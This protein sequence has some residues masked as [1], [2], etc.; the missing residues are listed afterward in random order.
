MD[1]TPSVAPGTGQQEDQSMQKA[2]LDLM[3]NQRCPIERHATTHA[4]G[5]RRTRSANWSFNIYIKGVQRARH[6]N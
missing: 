6:A 3:R 2:Y 5:I 4:Q 1:T